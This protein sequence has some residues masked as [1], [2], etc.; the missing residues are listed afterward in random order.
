MIE[1]QKL[2]KTL[3]FTKLNCRGLNKNKIEILNILEKTQADIACLN[4]AHLGKKNHPNFEGYTL[5][6]NTK[7]RRLGSAIYI[8][9]RLNY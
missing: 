8:Q 7:Q 4:E 3:T 2:Q 5:A 1:N 6:G 9:H